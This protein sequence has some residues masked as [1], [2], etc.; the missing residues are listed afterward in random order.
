MADKF[1]QDLCCRRF[2]TKCIYS[3]KIIYFRIINVLGGKQASPCFQIL[4]V[5]HFEIQGQ[6]I[7]FLGITRTFTTKI[8]LNVLL[9]IVTLYCLKGP[10]FLFKD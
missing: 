10:N 5:L 3:S 4:V 1:V 6:Y 8:I 7:I 9:V 2:R